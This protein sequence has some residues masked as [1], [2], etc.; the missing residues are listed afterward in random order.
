MRMGRVNGTKS[1][2]LEIVSTVTA[3]AI[4]S[5]PFGAQAL[6]YDFYALSLALQPPE[7]NLPRSL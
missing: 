3:S 2:H 6:S 4:A 7:N 5:R 1:E